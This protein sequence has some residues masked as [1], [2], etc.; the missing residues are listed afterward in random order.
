M[1]TDLDLSENEN[2]RL[3]Y[4]IEGQLYIASRDPKTGF[5]VLQN[6]KGGMIPQVLR[7]SFTTKV[8][9]EKAIETYTKDLNHK[10]IIKQ[11]IYKAPAYKEPEEPVKSK[12]I[13]K[14]TSFNKEV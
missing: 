11:G 10:K 2:K 5:W 1:F 13:S 9:L 7:G 3:P 12:A 8:A 14:P 4:D 6:E